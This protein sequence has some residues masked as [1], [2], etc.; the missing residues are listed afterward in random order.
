MEA[1]T[2]QGMQ[3]II[4]PVGDIARARALFRALLGVDP[5]MDKPYYVGFR[6]G[7]Q[8]IGLDPHGHRQGVTGYWH[9]ADI[10][11]TLQSLLDAGAQT[12][13]GV[14][15]SARAD[16]LPSC[17]TL[18][19]TLSDSSSRPHQPQARRAEAILASARTRRRRLR[20]LS[21]RRRGPRERLATPCPE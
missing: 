11:A 1:A 15:P 9:V 17:A 14:R 19:A 13:E 8:E 5:Y 3:T 21:S 10:R 12:I 16:S 20:K 7:G 6:A 18:T 2:I 4:Y